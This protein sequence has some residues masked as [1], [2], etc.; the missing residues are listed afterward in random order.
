MSIFTRAFWKDAAERSLKTLAQTAASTIGL[1]TVNV[2]A[3]DWAQIGGISLGAALVSVLMS[4]ASAPREG[5][6]SPA[7]IALPPDAPGHHA[8]PEPND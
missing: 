2:L 4:I 1:D 8:A 6:M 5:T 7:S 3:L